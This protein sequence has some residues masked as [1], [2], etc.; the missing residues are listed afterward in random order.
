MAT[1]NDWTWVFK[2]ATKC[3]W[4]GQSQVFGDHGDRTECDMLIFQQFA[5]SSLDCKGGLLRLFKFDCSLNKT[6]N[7]ASINHQKGEKSGLCNWIVFKTSGKVH[8]LQS[9]QSCSRYHSVWKSLKK[10]HFYEIYVY[11]FCPLIDDL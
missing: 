4:Q 5:C 10:S 3:I 2:Q 1:I 6:L 7:F 11:F 8:Q 9:N